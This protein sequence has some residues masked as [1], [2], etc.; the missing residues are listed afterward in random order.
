MRNE[1]KSKLIAFIIMAFLLYV[2]SI[3]NAQNSTIDYTQ[4][5]KICSPVAHQMTQQQCNYA[6]IFEGY[7][8]QC[9]Q[10]QGYGDNNSES[11][12]FYEGYMQAHKYCSSVSKQ[13][14]KEY[15]GY[16]GI[17]KSNYDR[18]MIKYGFNEYG[19]RVTPNSGQREFEFNF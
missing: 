3:T 5:Y 15:C 16:G 9:M 11:P 18:C 8:T 14:A 19:D 4:A 13:N 2:P 1:I 10:Q 17:Y 12:A 7:Y 6:R